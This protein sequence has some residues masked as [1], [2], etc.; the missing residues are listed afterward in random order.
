VAV[1]L[2]QEAGVEE[3][4]PRSDTLVNVDGTIYAGMEYANVEVYQRYF[5]QIGFGDEMEAVNAKSRAGERSGAVE[6]VSEHMTD[7][8]AVFG[9]AT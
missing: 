8:L 7:R 2:R 9:T 3:P 4:S 5:R 1:A 6:E